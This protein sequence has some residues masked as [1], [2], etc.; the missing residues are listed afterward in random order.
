M[1]TQP[2]GRPGLLGTVVSEPTM[3][4]ESTLTRNPQVVARE[5]S[6]AGGVLLH[7]ETGAYH[8]IN[9]LGF[10]IWVLLDQ[11]R[12]LDDLVAAV[13]GLVADAP[14]ELE[15]D[16]RS[17]VESAAKRDLIHIAT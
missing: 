14:P 17:F 2:G 1:G 13:R 9:Q 8:K 4:P 15:A 16:V 5:L 11:D 7:L 10:A 6:D 3:D 12:T